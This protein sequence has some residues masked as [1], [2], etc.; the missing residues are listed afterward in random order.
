[1]HSNTIS[2]IISTTVLTRSVRVHQIQCQRPFCAFIAVRLASVDSSCW[3]TSVV[4][5]VG[6]NTSD[7]LVLQV[8][9]RIV[10]VFDFRLFLRYQ[11]EWYI[12][13]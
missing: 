7:V 5:A 8:V 9:L 10:V 12:Y 6:D 13:R 3:D 4:L 2:R 11:H 1:M